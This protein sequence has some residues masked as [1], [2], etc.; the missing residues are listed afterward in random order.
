MRLAL[1]SRRRLISRQMLT[2]AV[3]VSLAG[4]ALGLAGSVVTLRVLSAWQPIPD[5]P[6]NIPV[7]PDARTYIV[8]LVLALASGLLFGIMP[9]RQIMRADP[10]Q[11]MRNGAA[12]V[13]GMRRL[14]LRDVLLV[15]QIA[16]CAVLVT[17][18]FVA[19]RGLAR[20]MQSNFGF[21]PQNAVLVETDLH[22][23]GYADDRIPQMQRRMLDATRDI[24]GVTAVG[25]ISQVPLG[26]GSGDS[27]VYSDSTTDYRPTKYSAEAMRYLIS[28]GYLD[29]AGTK[30]L[31][32]RDL[33][34]IDDKNAPK[35]ALVNR[36]FAV[37]VF[38]S[39]Q[40][41]IGA[42]FKYF[43]GVRAEVVGVVED[44]RAIAL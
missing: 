44:G 3:V 28:P 19:V 7:N 32:G 22:M 17:S 1:G 26:M 20:S 5:I 24:P 21:V 10:W 29:A 12:G 4:G 38:G 13:A 35:E 18:S 11:V 41:A 34:M 9:M 15:V 36:Q 2:E 31:A 8:A 37:K 33:R 14:T 23:A 30:L 16:I 27:Y 40:K 25:Y 6:I 42:H 39:V 43:G